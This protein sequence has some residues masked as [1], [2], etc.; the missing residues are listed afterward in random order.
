MNFMFT[1]K[2]VIAPLVYDVD[3]VQEA[4]KGSM[5]IGDNKQLYNRE[6]INNNDSQ[7]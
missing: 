5:C 4:I 2:S 3:D 1:V 6:I 7:V